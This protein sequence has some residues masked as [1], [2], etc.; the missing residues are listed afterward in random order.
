MIG[1]YLSG[2]SCCVK[3]GQQIQPLTTPIF[4]K[5]LKISQTIS[6]RIGNDMKLNRLA[7]LSKVRDPAIREASRRYLNRR[8]LKESARPQT[9]IYWIVPTSKGWSIFEFFDETYGELMHDDVWREYMVP[10]LIDRSSKK[11]PRIEIAYA[12]LPRGRVAITMPRSRHESA[13]KEF[14]VYHGNDTPEPKLLEYAKSR[15]NLPSSVRAVFDD[16]EVMIPEHMLIVRKQLAGIKYR[17]PEP[18][19]PFADD[20]L[21]TL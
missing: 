2:S 5:S 21:G 10:L 1:H 12:G 6:D 14:V 9:G 16:H 19:D 8:V 3:V 13:G 7:R 11:V 4:A 17:L 20:D 15:F 18:T